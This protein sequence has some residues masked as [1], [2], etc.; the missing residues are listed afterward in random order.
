MLAN[1]LRQS[2]CRCRPA[3]YAQ[4]L[5]PLSSGAAVQAAEAA[6]PIQKLFLD[7]IRTY[8]KKSQASGGAPVDAGKDFDAKMKAEIDKLTK[9]YSTTTK[10]D[11]TKFPE[12]TFED[13][14]LQV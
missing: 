1:T 14:K 4:V 13:P 11:L 6:D 2:L 10:G 3:V 5:R 8:S 7:N 12:F 9:Q